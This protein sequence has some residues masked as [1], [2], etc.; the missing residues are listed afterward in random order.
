LLLEAEGAIDLD[1]WL[2]RLDHAKA[3]TE[4]SWFATSAAD[5]ERFRRLR[6]ALAEVVNATVHANGFMKMGTDYAV[7]L[8]RN[9]EMLAFY[10][11]RLDHELPGQYVMYG[12]IGDAHVHVNMLP[13]TE[14]QAGTASALLNEFAAHAVALGGAVS[15][16]HGLGKRKAH[17][18]ALQY[19]PQ[20][21][22]AM[23]EVKRRLDP[24]WLLGRGNLFAP[25]SA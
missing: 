13:S 17:F 25:P 7:P 2:D 10:R 21:I 5:R 4:Q 20:Q 24:Q 23:I 1:A 8:D 15:G 6:H 12:H 19:S 22:N 14:Q 3:L 9:R 18:L 16:E 11:Q